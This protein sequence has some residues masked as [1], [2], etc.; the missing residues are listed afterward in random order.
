MLMD[1]A[2]NRL[3]VRQNNIFSDIDLMASAGKQRLVPV[4]H[5]LVSAARAIGTSFGDV[6]PATRASREP[7]AVF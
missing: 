3:V 7:S 5:P 4:D 1:G 2:R 6:A